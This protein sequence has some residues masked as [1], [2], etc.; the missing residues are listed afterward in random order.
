MRPLNSDLTI[1]APRSVVWD[2]LADIE[3]VAKW[4]PGIDDIECLSAARSGVGARRRCFT[5]P[6]GWMTESITEWIEGELI[7]FSIEDAA[8]LKQGVARFNLTDEQRSTRL[9]ASFEYEVKLGP[10]GPVIDRFVVHNRLRSTWN[11][12]IEGL[13]D[14]T[15]TRWQIEGIGRAASA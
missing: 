14:F 15:E 10:L 9:V 7:A 1:N 3:A 6:S 4:N 5:H 12:A 8:P 13:R 11:S 2:A